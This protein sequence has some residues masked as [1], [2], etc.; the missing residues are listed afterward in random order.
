MWPLWF[1]FI[2][3]IYKSPSFQEVQILLVLYWQIVGLPP[4]PND[5]PIRLDRNK[6]TSPNSARRFCGASKDLNLGLPSLTSHYYLPPCYTLQWY[7]LNA[8][9][10]PRWGRQLTAQERWITFFFS[11]FPINC[12]ASI[13]TPWTYTSDLTGICLKSLYGFTKRGKQSNVTDGKF[14]KSHSAYVKHPVLLSECSAHPWE[15]VICIFLWQ[16]SSFAFGMYGE[17]KVARSLF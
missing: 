6:M 9:C 8:C 1:S 11:Y 15:S 17:A 16:H 4:C 13:G 5:K 7:Q 14:T 2:P 10:M 12:L 3:H